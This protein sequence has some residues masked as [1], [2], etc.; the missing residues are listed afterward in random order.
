[1]AID[2]LHMNELWRALLPKLD[3]LEEAT[4][5]AVLAG[6]IQDI[7]DYRYHIGRLSMINDV[8]QAAQQAASD[9]YGDGERR[10]RRDAGFDTSNVDGA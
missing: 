4:R 5:T 2:Y 10:R 6:E 1:M 8:R 7:A 3:D 9:M